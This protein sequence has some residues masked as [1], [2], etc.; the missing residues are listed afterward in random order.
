M[1]HELKAIINASADGFIKAINTA[2]NNVKSFAKNTKDK[3]GSLSSAFKST[4][5]AIKDTGKSAQ[6][7]DQSFKTIG[8]S[9]KAIGKG[10]NVLTGLGDGLVKV[11]NPVTAAFTLIRAGVDY[12]RSAMEANIQ[13]AKD[14]A[15]QWKNT[16][17]AIAKGR[18]AY[19]ATAK[20]TDNYVK[21]LQELSEKTELSNTDKVE[22]IELLKKLG[23]EYARFSDVLK[24]NGGNIED[25]ISYKIKLDYQKDVSALKAEI[26]NLEQAQKIQ[27]DLADKWSGYWHQVIGQGKA[28]QTASEA[29]KKSLELTQQIIEKRLELRKLEN[30]DPESDYR[31]RR[32]AEKEDQKIEE[33]KKWQDTQDAAIQKLDEADADLHLDD[34]E[35]KRD[36]IRKK[37]EEL[38]KT[39]KYN[40]EALT[41]I[42]D[43]QAE[44]L[45][46]IDQQEADKRAE[47]A[48]KRA[49]AELAAEKAV[50]DAR[51][52]YFDAEKAYR[53]SIADARIAQ[54]KKVADEE[55][56]QLERVRRRIDKR[57]SRFGFTLDY[58]PDE[59]ASDA[60]KRRKT[61]AIDESI[62]EKQQTQA[63]GR[64]VHYTRQE[65]ARIS[66]YRSLQKQGKQVDSRIK[67]IEASQKQQ[68]AAS[69]AKAAAE[70]LAESAQ[71]QQDAAKDLE[72]AVAALRML[73][74]DKPD[75]TPSKNGGR[76]SAHSP[77]KP[78]SQRQVRPVTNAQRQPQKPMARPRQII[79]P[80]LDP[81][82]MGKP[83]QTMTAARFTPNYTQQ[84]TAILH[85]VNSLKSNTYIVR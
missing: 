84:L 78:T 54:A 17:D 48:K 28:R 71:R 39:L 52:K 83:M 30:T 76:A 51:K 12:I 85:S 74:G 2:W 3:V 41:R 36:A 26:R 33:N 37:Y 67:E 64:K 6:A 62:A 31:R 21:R 13:A 5:K 46:K 32:A 53:Q 49:D 34:F 18:A 73:R 40:K 38:A 16:A 75:V 68:E 19:A 9:I 66:E 11:F 14:L 72:D 81:K 15:E 56:R 27:A 69:Q 4:D 24:K 43:L 58:N 45:A 7:A 20:E 10:S 82:K 22:Q 8:D 61:N 63:E 50:M 70:R 1:K 44:E 55:I 35:K 42:A 25:A 29:D 47:E 57:M 65:K 80:M 60:R 23:A 59:K 77:Q 79:R